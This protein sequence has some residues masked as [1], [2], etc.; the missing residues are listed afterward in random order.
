MLKMLIDVIVKDS[1]GNDVDLESLHCTKIIDI[2][3]ENRIF[4]TTS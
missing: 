1:L 4:F 2:A 3:V